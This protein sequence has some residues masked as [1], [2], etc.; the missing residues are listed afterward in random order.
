[1]KKIKS[2]HFVGIKGVGMTPLAVIAKEAGLKVTGSDLEEEFITDITLKKAKI[3]PFNNFSDD[4]VKDVDLVVTTGAHDGFDNIEV[5]SAKN[6]NIKV[7]TQGEAV[8]IFMNGEIFNRKFEGISIAGCHG[9]TTTTAMLATIFRE[10]G[11]DPS[12]VIGTSSIASLPSCGHYGKGKYFIAEADEYATEPNFDKTPKFLWQHPRIMIF[13]N[14]EFD[15]PDLYKSVDDVREAF[16]LFANQLPNN[17]LLIAYCDDPQIQELIKEHNARVITFGRS[18]AND[19]TINKIHISFDQTFFW[20]EMRGVSLGEFVINVTGEHN[21]LNALGAMIVASECGLSFEKIKKGLKAF[22][23]SKRRFEYIGE[24]PSGALLF[25]DYA[26][27]P[28][29]IK[30]TLMAFKQRFPKSKI[31][32]IF[33]PHTY[34]RTKVL[35]NEFIDSLHFADFVIITDIY[36]S[37][38]EKPDLNFSAQLLADKLNYL[39]NCAIFLPSLSNVI[40]YLKQKKYKSDTVIVTMGAGDI[41]KIHN[42][43]KDK[44]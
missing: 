25:D 13:T 21:A 17:G 29:E 37:L 5:Q 31:I 28:T 10:N 41:Y 16:L 15:H 20:I 39:N 36:P 6:K 11:L 26:H 35:L 23:G 22:I 3:T 7:L 12:F 38:R 40:E 27:H 34:S 30:K 44:S 24:M 42:E 1:M 2:I 9:K 4:H 18:L 19:F 14:I 33:Q 43:L 8:G 32:C